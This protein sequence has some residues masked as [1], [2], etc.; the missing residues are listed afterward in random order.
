[1]FRV[2]YLLIPLAIYYLAEDVTEVILMALLNVGLGRASQD[3]IE[4]ATRYGATIR[5]IIYGIGLICAVAIL[6]PMGK[7]EI[8]GEE[9]EVKSKINLTN[10]F[11]LIVIGIIAS[12]GLNYIFNITGIVSMSSSYEAVHEAQYS[13]SFIAGILIYGICSPIAEELLFRAI[14]YNRLKRI[15]PYIASVIISALMFGV[16]HGNIVQGIYGTLMGLL[17]AWSYEKYK[18]YLAPVIIHMTANISVYIFSTL[19][20]K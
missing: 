2:A 18:N 7:N 5:S 13:V 8:I 4:N 20:W 12:V 17:L 6:M 16:F 9:G 15:F 11:T 10:V 14:I 3:F 1:M 19:I